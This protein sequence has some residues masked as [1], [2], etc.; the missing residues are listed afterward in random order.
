[1]V[2][3]AV[4]TQSK[5][6]SIT[7]VTQVSAVVPKNMVT[8]PRLANPIVTKSKSPIRWH[9]TCSQSP[10][11]SNSPLRVTAV[12]APVV[13]DAQGNMSYLSEFE[14]LK[15]GYVAFGGNPKGGKISG[16]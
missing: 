13:S 5:P 2:P 3:T 1:M 4:L 14:E 7:A 11:S 9:I 10:K 15:G 6:V 12:Q 16:K 8:Q